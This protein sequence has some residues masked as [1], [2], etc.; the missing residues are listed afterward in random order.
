MYILNEENLT[1]KL[2]IPI[3]FRTFRFIAVAADGARAGAGKIRT[4]RSGAGARAGAG[5]ISTPRS[6]AVK[7]KAAPQHCLKC[8]F[9]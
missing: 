2:S 4:P 3:P 6:G 8:S 5:K 7:R 9:L 1:D